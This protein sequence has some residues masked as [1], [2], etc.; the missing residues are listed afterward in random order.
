M[1]EDFYLYILMRNDMDSLNPGK[2]VAQGAHAA[3]VFVEDITKRSND[4]KK[5]YKKWAGGRG[6]GTTITLSASEKQINDLIS[7]SDIEYPRGMIIDETYPLKDGKTT[8]YFP[9]LT[10]AYIFA[11]RRYHGIKHLDLMK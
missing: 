4:Y 5:E 9:C 1:V 2:A 7:A 8:H 10:C 6:Y 11:P 3:N